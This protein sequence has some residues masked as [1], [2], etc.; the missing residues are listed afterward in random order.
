MITA[1]TKDVFYKISDALNQL[2]PL[3]L[4]ECRLTFIMRLPGDEE[5]DVL[6]TIDD[7]DELQ[8]LIERRKS[9]DSNIVEDG[10]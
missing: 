10:R 5:A 2:G 9:P 8:K 3:F 7:L 1:P 4:P 6:V